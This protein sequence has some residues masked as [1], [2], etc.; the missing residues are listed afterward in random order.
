ML[1][2]GLAVLG[3]VDFQETAMTTG[4]TIER[5]KRFADTGTLGPSTADAGRQASP[6]RLALYG[7]PRLPRSIYFCSIHSRT[8]I[9]SVRSHVAKVVLGRQAIL[10]QTDSAAA[11]VGAN[12]FVLLSIE[13]A[14]GKNL[15]Q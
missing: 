8:S 1:R 2:G 11:Q 7:L 14:F 5:M 3:Q 12:R 15:L 10:R 6:R 9:T 13:T 4:K